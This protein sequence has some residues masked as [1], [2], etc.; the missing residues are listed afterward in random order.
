VFLQL[1]AD[2]VRARNKL[3]IIDACRS[4][5]NDTEGNVMSPAFR[6]ELIEPGA[7]L[8]VIT[9]CDSGESSYEDAELSMGGLPGLCSMHYRATAFVPARSTCTFRT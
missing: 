3:F 7:R 2:D 1:S 6:D 9:G 8:A 4:S 5:P